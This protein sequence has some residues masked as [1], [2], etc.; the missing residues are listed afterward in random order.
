MIFKTYLIHGISEH[1]E[2]FDFE[3]YHSFLTKIGYL[4]P[5]VEDFE[6]TTANVDVEITVQAGP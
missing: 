5:E 1:R 6:I 2:D 4:E 3:S